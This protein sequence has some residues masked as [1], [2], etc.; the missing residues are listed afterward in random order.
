ML[1][2]STLGMTAFFG[3]MQNC[4][5]RAS[6]YT[7]F[8]ATKEMAFVPLSTESKQKGK[9]AIDGVGS[10]LG[11][12]GGSMIHQGLLVTFGT[13]S[14][15]APFVGII[16]LITIGSWMLSVKSLGQQ[17][18]EIEDNPI[19]EPSDQASIKQPIKS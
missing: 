12:S 4:F 13:V 10:R 6:K 5:A 8:D 3:S 14:L 17:F 1:S 15:S 7:F 11:K 18:Q 19:L 9:A 2:T 16:L